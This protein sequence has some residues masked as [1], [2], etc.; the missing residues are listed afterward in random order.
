MQGWDLIKYGAVFKKSNKM[1]Y[2]Q[3]CIRNIINSLS[4]SSDFLYWLQKTFC[5]YVFFNI[6]VSR[7]AQ[8]LLSSFYE[9]S[10]LYIFLF[11]WPNFD[12]V[13]CVEDYFCK[14]P[15]IF[16]FH[17]F[18]SYFFNFLLIISIKQNHYNIEKFFL[19]IL[20]YL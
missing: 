9:Q 1:Y 6:V 14:T 20:R 10:D 5:I 2:T 4:P 12:H 18:K 13:E 16:N 8:I 11:L 3:S 15:L 7:M 19:P 17:K